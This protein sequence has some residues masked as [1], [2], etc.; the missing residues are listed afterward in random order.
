MEY[1]Y[2]AHSVKLATAPLVA[3]YFG[4][5]PCWFVLSNLVA[6]PLATLLLYGTLITV[7]LWPVAV[8]QTLAAK[9]V[10]LMACVLNYVLGVIAGLPF[11]SVDGLRPTVLQVVFSYILIA[12]MLRLIKYL[13]V[14]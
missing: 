4:S 7:I 6:V 3:Y 12:L 10:G 11:S 13:Q 5:L 8:L 1:A 14:K 9:A 2:G